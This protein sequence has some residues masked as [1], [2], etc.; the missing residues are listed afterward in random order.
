M[1]KETALK[2]LMKLHNKVLFSE[3]TALETFIPEIKECKD[4]IIRKWLIDAIKAVPNDSI[5]WDII[6]K[7]DVLVWL[8]KQGEQKEINLV[9]I[10]KHYPR[11]TELYSPLYGK[12]W[13]A[14]ADEKH[15]TITCYKHR[16]D[17]GC[18]RAILE[19]EDTV[20]FYSNGTTGLPDFSVSKDCMLFLYNNEKQGEQ[21]QY[22]KPS[23]EQLDALDYAYNLCP[24][25]ERGDYY[26]GVLK[27][28]I[29][30]LHKLS[31]KQGEQ[32][33]TLCDKCRKTQP[34]HSCQDITSLGR[35]ALEKQGEQNHND[36]K[37][38]TV[39]KL[40]A[41][42]ECLE[43]NGDCSFNGYSGNE[44]GKFLRKLSKTLWLEK[45]GEQPYWKTSEEQMQTL[46][47]QLNEGAVTYPEDKRILFTLYEDLMKIMT[48]EEK[49][50]V[51]KPADKVESKFKA[52]DW[53]V[54]G[55]NILKIKC[56]GHT[57]YCFETVGGY[58]ADMLVSEIDSLYHLWTIQDAKDGDILANGDMV[59]IFKCF[60]E[61][62]YRQH[63][64]AYIGLDTCGNIQVTDEYWMLGIDG[65]KPATKKQRDFLLQKMKEAGYEWD[66]EK[67]KLKEID[68]WV[69]LGLPSG[70]L[71][72][73]SNETD[74]NDG[75]YDLYTYDDAMQKFGK[76][77]PT[78]E[79]WEELKNT[80]KWTW[81]DNGY[82]VTGPNGNSIFLPASGYRYCCD[83]K[84]YDVGTYGEYW[85]SEPRNSIYV[86]GCEFNWSEIGIYSIN[87]CYGMSV[88]LVNSTVH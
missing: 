30:D 86:Y 79:H 37:N 83:G 88:R 55:R 7:L 68:D 64:I 19:Q 34:S 85:S 43:M 28:I 42:A 22:W 75:D 57:Y 59:L 45:Q 32:K 50:D 40:I 18:T 9:E 74:P 12:L 8:E 54:Q 70:T 21:S 51:Q 3:R 80:C 17:E 5:E 73:S 11:E 10:L 66:S 77:L 33:E 36:D 6:N 65:A 1:E 23:K 49:Q 67:K 56:V 39:S 82:N 47:T 13:L 24:D 14:E 15:E 58:V 76:Q 87:N 29:D 16:L 31:E 81:A 38:E 78:K 60:E 25:T 84:V 35:C 53:V 72:K 20:S 27:T 44:C 69:D 63:I 48:Q 62:S 52:G 71:W 61:P 46:H 2:I 41:I 4:E 26:E